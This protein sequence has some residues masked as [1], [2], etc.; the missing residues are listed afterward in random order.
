MAPDPQR[1]GR[2]GDRDAPRSP[3]V[4]GAGRKPSRSA[5]I[6]ALFHSRAPSAMPTASPPGPH[7]ERRGQAVDAPRAR[8]T[9]V[10]VEEDREGEPEP[11]DVGPRAGRAARRGPTETPST[12]SPRAR[13]RRQQR[14][15]RRH[16][17]GAGLAPRCPEVDDHEAL[18][19]LVECSDA[20]VEPRQPQRRRAVA[21]AQFADA[22]ALERIERRRVGRRGG[23]RPDR[24]AERASA[25]RKAAD[26]RHRQHARTICGRRPTPS[27]VLDAQLFIVSRRLTSTL[28]ARASP[29]QSGLGRQGGARRQARDDCRKGAK[30]LRARLR[31][32]H[33]SP[34]YRAARAPTPRRRSRPSP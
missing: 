6:S 25:H 15:E 31:A 1:S 27:S 13:Y 34:G 26:E 4:G 11:R 20:A 14:L 32:F 9:Q 5:R 2:P 18:A 29:A 24:D 22:G 17:G 28:R 12:T 16:L 8:R 30:P 7:H 23:R 3:S 10:G 21:L 33:G 19:M